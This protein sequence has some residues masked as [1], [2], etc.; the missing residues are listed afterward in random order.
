MSNLQGSQKI[1][2]LFILIFGQVQRHLFPQLRVFFTVVPIILRCAHIC[3]RTST[4]P[5]GKLRVGWISMKFVASFS[6]VT[7]S[8]A[9]ITKQGTPAGARIT[10]KHICVI[11]IPRDSCAPFRGIVVCSGA[12]LRSCTTSKSIVKLS[13]KLC[14]C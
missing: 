13:P 4:L 3:C 2:Q 7:C 9:E 12:S 10:S 5:L 11:Q 14:G 1:E 8:P 6:C